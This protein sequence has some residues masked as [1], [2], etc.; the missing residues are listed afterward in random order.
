MAKE[1]HDIKK[2]HNDYWKLVNAIDELCMEALE[3][4]YAEDIFEA[5][6]R[7]KFHILSDHIEAR[8]EKRL[9]KSGIELK[10]F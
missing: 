1:K 10:E 8:I 4:L 6:E 9:E 5:L 3:N 2:W 7:V